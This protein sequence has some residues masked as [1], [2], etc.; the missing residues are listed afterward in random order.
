M[1]RVDPAQIEQGADIDTRDYDAVDFEK[2]GYL[3]EGTYTVVHLW[4]WEKTGDGKG[5]RWGL[6][7]GAEL[8]LQGGGT[9]KGNWVVWISQK[10]RGRWANMLKVLDPGLFTEG[11]VRDVQPENYVG[12]CF[13]IRMGY[14][15]TGDRD[16]D[17]LWPQALIPLN[18]QEQPNPGATET[19]QGVPEDDLPF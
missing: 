4:G 11:V 14:S 1:A 19:I 8:P 3:Q 13:K 16:R 9:G 2:E 6:K 18:G 10:H 5:L 7:L 15:E 12:T 17:K